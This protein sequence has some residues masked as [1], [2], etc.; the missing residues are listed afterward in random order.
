[1][2]HIKELRYYEVRS[3]KSGDCQE[4]NPGHIWF[5]PPVPCYGGLWGACGCPAVVGS[6]AEHWRLKP[7]VFWV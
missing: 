2:K 3:E 6:V 7:E 1:M 4:S 5:E